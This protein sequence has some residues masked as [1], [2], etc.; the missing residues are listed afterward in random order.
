MSIPTL[1]PAEVCEKLLNQVKT[2]NLNYILSE[3][4]YSANI[5]IR[6]WFQKN[7]VATLLSSESENSYIE[8]NKRLKMKLKKVETENDALKVTVRSLEKKAEK[9]ESD[10]NDF[11]KKNKNVSDDKTED[12]KILKSVIKKNNEEI[13]MLKVDSGQRNKIIKSKEKE[14]FNLV[15]KNENQMDTIKTLKENNNSLK[16]EI[17]KLDKTMKQKKKDSDK[18]IEALI[19]SSKDLNENFLE[20]D[21]KTEMKT[22][23]DNTTTPTKPPAPP[24][25]PC[26][27]NPFLSPPVPQVPP[28]PNP[29]SQDLHFK[30]HSSTT[31]P[32][33]APAE[34][35]TFKGDKS[36]EPECSIITVEEAREIIDRAFEKY[37]G[38]LS[39]N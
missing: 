13:S 21:A 17:K 27:S 34:L 36:P 1:S 26:T 6:K 16:I 9:A 7:K 31:S 15:N 12:I 14:I 35:D 10:L 4:P 19:K 28:V 30:T 29:P 39:T 25:I 33:R 2:S 23:I 8:D 3:T 18:K 37:S 5:C 32:N 38:K 24:T 11:K 22:F 20:P